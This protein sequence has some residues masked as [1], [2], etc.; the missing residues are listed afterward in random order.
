MLHAGGDRS[1]GCRL[2][3][4]RKLELPEIAPAPGRDF[5][6]R[7]EGQVEAGA[8]CGLFD[9]LARQFSGDVV[10]GKGVVSP[11]DK[12]AVGFAGEGIAAAGGDS[13]DAGL[14]A[15]GNGCLSGGV[16]AP[17][18]HPAVVGQGE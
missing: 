5:A 9:L 6:V 17:G 15:G 1:D 16:A 13:L 7:G 11:G 3:G 8:G 10:L 14:G 18:G 12:G 4:V 2:H